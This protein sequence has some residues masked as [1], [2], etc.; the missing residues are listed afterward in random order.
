LRYQLVAAL[1]CCLHLDEPLSVERDDLLFEFIRGPEGRM[2]GVAV[3]IR[4][5]EDELGMYL[6][7]FDSKPD[8]PNLVAVVRL[9]GDSATRDRLTLELQMLESELAFHYRDRVKRMRWD[10]PT[11][12]ILAET[13]EEEA[14]P[15]ITGFSQS[16]SRRDKPVF[17]EPSDVARMATKLPLYGDLYILKGFLRHAQNHYLDEEYIQAFAQAYLVVEALFAGGKFKK[18]AVL[19]EFAESQTLSRICEH[20]LG[21]DGLRQDHRDSLEPLFKHYRCE[22]LPKEIPRFLFEVR[23]DLFHFSR[24]SSRALHSPFRQQE[25]KGAAFLCEYV[26][27]L[28]VMFEVI[29]INR[30]D[31]GLEPIEAFDDDT[32][33]N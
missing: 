12:N 32:S 25:F 33:P 28:G 26:A 6:G 30:R 7:S 4:I 20:A 22:L 24:R 15:R 5:P 21:S 29:S 27:S 17:V 1:D 13:E 9:G 10:A 16:T 11:R 23:G 31:Q 8:D 14:I 19:E 3:S 18:V 2:T